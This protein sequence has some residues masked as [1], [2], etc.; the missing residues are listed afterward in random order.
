MKYAMKG[1]KTI[2]LF[3]VLVLIFGLLSACGSSSPAPL[4]LEKD[5]GLELGDE[6][7][8]IRQ[9]ARPLLA[10]LGDHYELYAA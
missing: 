2:G 3:T 8:P 6:W 10:A 7:H 1:L 4:T 9:D 5:F